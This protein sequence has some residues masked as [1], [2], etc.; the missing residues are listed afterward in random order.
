[1][2]NK[3]INDDH[4]NIVLSITSF[5]EKNLI[6]FDFR[7]DPD[8]LISEEGPDPHQN[9]KDPKDCILRYIISAFFQQNFGFW[10][11]I[12]TT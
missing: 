10:T 3:L 8:P 11:R 4:K 5:K 6:F 7:S 2:N 12:L 9:E 1:V